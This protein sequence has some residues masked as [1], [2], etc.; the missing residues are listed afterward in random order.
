MMTT[1]GPDFFFVKYIGRGIKRLRYIYIYIYIYKRAERILE[2][3]KKK[4]F[5]T[6]IRCGIFAR[7][8]I[9]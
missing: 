4:V 5:D 3:N 8:I 6:S 7:D 2:K 9:L 1:A